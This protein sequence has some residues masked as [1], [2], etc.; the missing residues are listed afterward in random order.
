[1]QVSHVVVN[2]SPLIC[3]FKS[4]LADILP[5]L[6]QEI[7]VPDNVFKEV[8]TENKYDFASRAVKTQTWINR[9]SG[10]EINP[11]IASWDL[12]KGESAVLSFAMQNPYFWVVI[13]DMA[14]R[15]CALS[16][17]CR[18]TGTVGLIVLAK[19]RG[20]INSVRESIENLQ[21]VGLWLSEDFI[22]KVCRREGE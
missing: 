10:I 5:Q 12:G 15:R 3:L 20:I 2:A 14:A 11:L 9:V 1:M 19:R 7:A 18:F 21:N 13:D 17:G 22:E 8:A 16:L 6:F 4:G